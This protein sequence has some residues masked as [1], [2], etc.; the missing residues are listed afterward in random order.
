MGT[1]SPMSDNHAKTW[2]LLSL[3]VTLLTALLTPA[4]VAADTGE[5]VRIS[6]FGQEDCSH[7]QDLHL[8]PA[9]SQKGYM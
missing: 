2:W 4:L 7:C 9:A 3:G 5:N 1:C 6:I 8:I